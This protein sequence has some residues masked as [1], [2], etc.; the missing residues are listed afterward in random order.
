MKRISLLFIFPF[1]ALVILL[2]ALS[3][4]MFNMPPFGKI[5][6]PF[7]GIVQSEQEDEL[8]AKEV[9]I[10]D[11]FLSG[12]VHVYFD[13]RRVPHIYA[14]NNADLYFTQG[15]VTAYLRLWQ[16]DFLSYSIA[17]RLSEIFGERSLDYDRNQRRT[18]IVD[19][20]K[21]SLKVM[22][23]HAETI[24]A[25]NAYT[26]GVNAYIRTLSYKN[27]P[28]EYK[29]LEYTPEPWSAL[30]TVLLMKSMGNTLSGYEED[31]NNTNLMLALGEETFNQLFPD[32]HSYCAPAIQGTGA[33]NKDI[34]YTRK[35]PYLD[36]SFMASGTAGRASEYNPHLG[37][38]SWV[39]SGAKTASGH[40]ILCSD[41][42][43]NLTLPAVWLEMQLSAPGV[44]VYGVSIPGTPA[45][46]I[47]FNEHVSWGLTNGQDDVK[48][49]YKMK[50]KPGYSSYELDGRWVPLKRHIE[51]IGVRGR[52]IVLDTEYASVQGPIVST[53]TFRGPRP[54][55]LDH[56]LRWELLQPSDEFSTFIKLNRARNYADFRE[57]IKTYACPVQNFTFASQTGDIAFKH[58]GNIM[59]KENGQGKFILDGS[60]AF[61]S[62]EKYIPQDSLPAVLNPAE[63]Y[64][65]SANQHPTDASYPYYYNGYF[66][67]KRASRIKQLLENADHLDIQAMMRVQLDNT[68]YFA[69]SIVPFLVKYVDT[70]LLDAGQRKCFAQLSEWKGTYNRED[71]NAKMY[72]LWWQHIKNDTWDELDGYSFKSKKPDDYILMQ[73]IEHDTANN[74]FDRQGTDVHE[75][76]RDIIQQA[77]QDAYAENEQ[78]KQRGRSTW[79]DNNHVFVMHMTNIGAFSRPNIP[80]AGNPDAINA[81]EGG[82]G[83][84]WRMIVE[85]GEWPV[86]YGIY[87]GGQSGHVRGQFYSNFVDDWSKGNYYQL[88][89]YKSQKDAARSAVVA[90]KFN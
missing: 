32:Y 65:V 29:F 51:E 35:P 13:N 22:E 78:L 74:Y 37:S 24:T 63:G 67:E 62:T 34:A 66:N 69:A 71:K 86:A 55:L 84:S 48:D 2:Y 75:S 19:A 58:Q 88:A 31:Y 89:F 1:L 42:H 81:M 72:E 9:T 64:I 47:G 6:N 45:I 26:A 79:A 52:K 18:G 57:A 12:P 50:I 16:M 8:Y 20:A 61:T 85:M 11:P 70:T 59:V 87:P 25:V 43:L 53:A 21:A 60:R 36:Y 56:A 54:E 38:N 5:A 40:P 39:V 83:P 68:N 33:P 27:M 49:W 14:G 77:F 73:M 28:L 30:K 10:K 82:W 7:I 41:P 46:I 90:W 44:N 80:S 17:G 3:I 4:Q 23:G 76:A 15:Y